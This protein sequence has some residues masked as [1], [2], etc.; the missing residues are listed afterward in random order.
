MKNK[1]LIALSALILATG[2]FAKDIASYR[3]AT[4]EF[5]NGIHN[6]KHFVTTLAEDQVLRVTLVRATGTAAWNATREGE[7]INFEQELGDLIF[8]QL[9]TQIA[10][11]SN[12][13]IKRVLDPMICMM[14]PG[15][16]QSN[17]HLSVARDY[18]WNTRS[19]LGE[20]ELILGPQGCWVANKVYPEHE[21]VTQQ[22]HALK[23]A[24][25]FTTLQILENLNL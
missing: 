10:G 7:P 14:M 3:F 1:L 24:L 4:S 6:I 23:S 17:D 13:P 16:I 5:A 22:A 20:L 15:P 12:A 19:F 25:K 18:D 9:R 11:I 2:A 21:R 8:N